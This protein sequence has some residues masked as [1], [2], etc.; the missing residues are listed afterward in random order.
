LS[1]LWAELR[2]R[3]VIRATVTYAV[4]AVGVGGAADVF[5]PGL[6]APDW[7]LATVLVLR[8]VP[9]GAGRN[10]PGLAPRVRGRNTVRRVG[11]AHPTHRA[12]GRIPEQSRR[13][14][15]AEAIRV[16]PGG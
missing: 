5:L 8:R 12:A 4:V 13:S 1:S 16:Q 11:P 10:A 3:R 14:P 6:G 9:D 2:R 15:P 7:A